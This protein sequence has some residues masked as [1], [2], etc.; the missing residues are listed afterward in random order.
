MNICAVEG[1]NHYS[2]RSL[3]NRRGEESTAVTERAKDL[4]N[5]ACIS[6]QKNGYWPWKHEEM[7]ARFNNT[8]VDELDLD[9]D[10]S[11]N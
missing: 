1:H 9:D 11:E 5:N 2:T 7:R 8:A 10:E 3:Q 4:A 6:C